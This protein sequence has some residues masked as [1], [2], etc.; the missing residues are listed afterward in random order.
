MPNVNIKNVTVFADNIIVSLSFSLTFDCEI[1]FSVLHISGQFDR[2][3]ISGDLSMYFKTCDAIASPIDSL[4]LSFSR[5]PN[6]AMSMSGLLSPFEGIIHE[7]IG[8]EITSLMVSPNKLTIKMTKEAQSNER[9]KAAVRSLLV[10]HYNK[11]YSSCRKGQV[12]GQPKV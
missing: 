11:V 12:K 2:F 8:K 4:T 9:F 3:A 1:K 7:T 6:T 5:A 10:D